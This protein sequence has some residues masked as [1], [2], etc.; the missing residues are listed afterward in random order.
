MKD[1]FSKEGRECT[2]FPSSPTLYNCAYRHSGSFS[3]PRGKPIATVSMALEV[4]VT[5]KPLDCKRQT[6]SCALVY[7]FWNG[8]L[9]LIV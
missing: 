9:L 6:R 2:Q 4:S 1:I 3:H 8:I 5:V 7:G